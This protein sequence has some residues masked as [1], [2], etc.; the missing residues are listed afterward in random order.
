MHYTIQKQLTP[1]KYKYY[2]Q[3]QAA[4]VGAAVAGVGAAVT[5]VGAAVAGVGA[6][7]AGVQTLLHKQHKLYN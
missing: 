6:A 1:Y 7:V 3:K 4:G 5:G 2:K